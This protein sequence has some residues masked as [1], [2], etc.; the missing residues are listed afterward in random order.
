VTDRG[1]LIRVARGA[2][3]A[4][5]VLTGGR[6]F[7]S[8][9]KEWL[10]VDVAI[11]EGKIAGLGSFEGRQTVDARGQLLVPGLIDAHVH[12]ESSKLMVDEFARAV[13]PHG[14]TAVVTDPHEIANVLG[15]DGIHWLLDV[16]EALPLEV[17]VM[18]SSC[19]PASPYESP[20][21]PLTIGD[22]ESI[23]RRSHA[24]GVAEMMNFPAVIAAQSSE[25]RKLEVRGATHVDGHAP[26]LR[27]R[28][29]DA[30]LAAGIRSDHEATTYEEALEKRRKGMWVLIRDASNAHNLLD[31]LPLV[32]NYGP[33]NCAF[34]TDDREPDLLVREGHVNHMCRLAVANGVAPEDAILLA[35][36]HPARYHGLTDL[37]AIAPGFVA[38]LVMLPDLQ[39]FRPTKVFARG[40]L[41][42][43]QGR[44]LPFD[45][46]EVPVWVR[47]SVRIDPVGRE[48]LRID[49]RGKP[50]RVIEV[51]PGQLLT[52]SLVEAPRVEQG[53]AIA[54]PERDL[55]KI[56][57][58]E[59]H[60]AT[61]RLGKGFV[62]GF[63][64]QRGAFA[65]SVAHDAHNLVVVGVSDDDMV[66]C[67]ERL[68]TIGGGIVVADEGRVVAE[69]PLPVAGLLSDEPVGAV[70]RRMDTVH[71][72]LGGLGVKIASPI[73]TL[74]FL[75][76]SV[77]P[78]LKITDLGLV[79]VD[80]FAIVALEVDA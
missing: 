2:E 5:V 77:I 78:S 34:C 41:V 26:G 13:L 73:M 69:L 31:L 80:R 43:D 9:T 33:E 22:M 32:K 74:S 75:A 39:S 68:A 45:R 64:L 49:S 65:S 35:S 18:A 67:V 8:F 46:R 19:V 50:V 42:V 16:C 55:A 3:P 4:D 71:E 25:L 24:L 59:R 23:L 7:A 54:D 70:V 20:R 11:A 44:V 66:A 10:E 28:Q 38:D 36:L 12:I 14:T 79:D 52:N 21:R 56:A 48:Q 62:K 15:T 58:I 6:V 76:L 1:R 47:N 57:V 72:Q 60:H 37:G 40:E 27:G 51:V 30:Y 53:A 61:G 29:L 17:F 63:G